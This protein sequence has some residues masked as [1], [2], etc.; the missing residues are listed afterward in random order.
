MLFVRTFA[1]LVPPIHFP[2]PCG[3]TGD[4]IKLCL[5]VPARFSVRYT[6]RQLLQD[7]NAFGL[8][9]LRFQFSSFILVLYIGLRQKEGRASTR[10]A[11]DRRPP[12]ENLSWDGM[13]PILVQV[14]CPCFLQGGDGMSGGMAQTSDPGNR[15][16]GI[17]M[18]DQGAE[19]LLQSVDVSTRR[20][21]R[22]H[23]G[24]RSFHPMEVLKGGW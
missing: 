8:K 21:G 18:H 20:L 10:T 23:V 7:L 19:Q 24:S 12:D 4:V 14:I 6:G 17:D 13:V 9:R 15:F 2:A 1:P 22:W 16:E 11:W 5:R 3:R